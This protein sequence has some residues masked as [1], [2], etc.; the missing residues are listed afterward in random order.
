MT[1][2]AILAARRAC[3]AAEL[4]VRFRRPIA[5]G[6]PLRIEGTV[7]QRRSRLLRTTG[8]IR[9][10]TGAARLTA[11]GKYVPMAEEAEALARGDFVTGAGSIDPAGLF[12][13]A[14]ARGTG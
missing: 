4:S 7:A 9:D 11:T 8:V 3:V 12:G 6:Q 10:T 1:W 5:V 2:A 14:A 13:N